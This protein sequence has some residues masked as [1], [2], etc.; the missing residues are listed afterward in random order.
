[1]LRPYELYKATEDIY[2]VCASQA[3]YTISAEDRKNGKVRTAE[4][5]EEIGVGGGMWHDGM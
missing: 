2:N 4:G 1:M 5:G 3:A